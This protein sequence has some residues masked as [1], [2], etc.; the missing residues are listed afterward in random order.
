MNKIVLYCKSYRG[1]LKR[2]VCLW[3]SIQRHNVDQLPFYVSVPVDDVTMFQR[4]LG[5]DP[6]CIILGDGVVVGLDPWKAQQVVKASFWRTEVCENYLM[7]D[8]DSYFIRDFRESDFIS[9]EGIPYTVMHEQKELFNWT[10]NKTDRLGFDPQQS[11]AEARV[12]IMD[13]FDRKGR[14]YDFGPVP[15][16][17]NCD[18]WR[19]LH[20]DYLEPNGMSFGDAIAT[21][22]SEFTWY[23]EWLLASGKKILPIEPL[24]KVFHYPGQY[25]E[26]KHGGYTEA[27][28]AKV[29]MGIVMQS[30][31]NPPLKY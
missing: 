1:D 5:N 28:L 4:E 31:W 22:P 24:F 29:Y 30:N 10:C 6:R 18:T 21:V 20:T 12:K 19:S 9:P 8:A 25:N 13:I 7:L 2:T 27:H 17:W 14:L 3:E 26:Y 11:F 15:V 23:G 16:I